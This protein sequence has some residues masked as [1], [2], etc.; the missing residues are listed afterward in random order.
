MDWFEKIFRFV[1]KA[2]II[3]GVFF[4]I[5]ALEK[6]L[7]IILERFVGFSLH[8]YTW[9]AT[10]ATIYHTLV[11]SSFVLSLAFLLV[12]LILLLIRLIH[13]E[14][15]TEAYITPKNATTPF[16]PFHN[17]THEEEKIIEDLFEGL[18]H[19][20]NYE[21]RINLS[22][23]S[24]YL[25]ALCELGYISPRNSVDK[26]SIQQWVER[27]TKKKTPSQSEFNAA[28]PST[29]TKEIEKAKEVIKKCLHKA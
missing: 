27:V 8:T 26:P 25:T 10:I 4:G 24:R 22:I 6:L 20:T 7:S 5:L 12:L 2:A 16:S 29:N 1:K 15:K 17:L 14:Q 13:P 18:P 9:A 3:C 19:H 21:D 23:V 28:Y 11:I